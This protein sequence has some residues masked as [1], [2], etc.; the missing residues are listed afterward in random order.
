MGGVDL[1]GPEGRH[2]EQRDVGQPPAHE[3]QQVEAGLVG[4]VRVLDD[5]QGRFGGEQAAHPAEQP[6]PVGGG[7]GVAQ[8]R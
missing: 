3:A 4:P 1:V 6:D 5:E 2:D 7:G 8:L